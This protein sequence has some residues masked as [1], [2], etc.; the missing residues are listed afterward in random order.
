[1]I[2]P[3]EG[4][5]DTK[6]LFIY[7]EFSMNKF[8][9]EKTN[10]KPVNVPVDMN[11]AAITG[12]RIKLDTGNRLA[13]HIHMGDSTSAT[14]SFTLQQHNASTAGT[15]KA[16]SVANPYYHKKAALDVFTKVIPDTATEAYDLSSIFANDEGIVVFEVLAEDLDVEGGYYWASLNVA[17]SGAAKLISAVYIVHECYDGPP[18]DVAI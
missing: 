17:D 11:S 7:K 14:A 16:L 6:K 12:A 8:L 15:S 4:L 10:I 18:Y 9:M 3:D 13:I 1:V 2:I 5:R